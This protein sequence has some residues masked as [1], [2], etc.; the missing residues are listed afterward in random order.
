MNE[1]C[2]D[3]SKY[4]GYNTF[5]RSRG[6]ACS[7]FK[8][9]QKKQDGYSSKIILIDEISFKDGKSQEGE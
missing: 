4:R 5:D 9:E 2:K 8:K 1:T 6:M 3:C 7:E